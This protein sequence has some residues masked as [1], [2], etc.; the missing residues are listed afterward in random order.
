MLTREERK[1]L[2]LAI[3]ENQ[4][5]DA[6]F[7]HPGMKIFL[8]KAQ[9]MHSAAN[10]LDGITSIEDLHFKRGQLHVLK[11][12]LTWQRAVKDTLVGLV[13]DAEHEARL[14]EK[15]ESLIDL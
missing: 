10:N 8:D 13:E 11:W 14:H 4:L 1:E 15:N 6:V 9:E 2:L 3:E 12:F 5:L 7:D